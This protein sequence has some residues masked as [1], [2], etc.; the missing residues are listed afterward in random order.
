[1][2]NGKSNQEDGRKDRKYG[3]WDD[4][5]S[6]RKGEHTAAHKENYTHAYNGSLAPK[7]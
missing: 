7:S 6:L 2:K 1:M 4:E 5:V 3:N